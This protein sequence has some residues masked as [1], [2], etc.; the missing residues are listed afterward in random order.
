M[1]GASSANQPDTESYDYDAPLTE[2]G[3]PTSKYFAIQSQITN[4]TGIQPTIPVPPATQKFAYGDVPFMYLAD[5]THLL[6]VLCLPQSRHSS[7][8]PKTV[9]QI[10]FGYGYALYETVLDFD[11]YANL[12]V[13]G[14]NDRGYVM[15][16]G[17]VQ[18]SV[19]IWTQRDIQINA[20][21]GGKLQV[22]AENMGRQ[23]MGPRDPKG[24]VGNVTLNKNILKNWIIYPLTFENIF[25]QIQNPKLRHKLKLKSKRAKAVNELFA[26]AVYYT[27]FPATIIADTYFNTLNW[28]KGQFFI[29]GFNVGRYW[30]ALGPQVTMYVPKPKLKS[31]NYAIMVEVE[32][33][34]NCKQNTC[35][36]SFQDTPY[37]DKPVVPPKLPISKLKKLKKFIRQ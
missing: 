15:V 18:G 7:K 37:I 24:I 16:N 19:S 1:N 21:S 35:W 6:D 2:A 11:G 4:L 29:N 25:D 36:A 14:I 22:L 32:G 10:D 30:P 3:D 27:K 34:T 9:E 8:Y 20:V 5:I 31:L 26:P 23:N 12:S 17:V 28:T 33:V 13:P